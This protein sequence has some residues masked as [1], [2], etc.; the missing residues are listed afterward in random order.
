MP[1]GYILKIMEVKMIANVVKI[2]EVV[3]TAND[4]C[5]FIG[6][7]IQSRK[8]RQFIK[9]WLEWTEWCAVA[10]VITLKRRGKEVNAD[11]SVF[12]QKRTKKMENAIARYVY[13]RNKVGE[14]VL[15]S[16]P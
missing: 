6:Q 2:E 14:G 3:A 15:S 12:N 13:A 16:F 11:F 7:R 10:R 5:A 9:K 1:Y 8:R 4:M